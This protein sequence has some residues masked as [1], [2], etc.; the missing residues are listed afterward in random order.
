MEE[1]TMNILGI[2]SKVRINGDYGALSIETIVRETKTLWITN[3][4]TRINK[5]NKC[6][7]GRYIKVE[8]AM[9]KDFEELEKRKL[10][11]GLNEYDFSLLDL[12][13]L[14]QIRNLIVNTQATS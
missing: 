7:Q 2:G 12:E 14:R 9:P 3:K 1:L 11:Y 5:E 6:I 13:T 8:L 10:G 4:D